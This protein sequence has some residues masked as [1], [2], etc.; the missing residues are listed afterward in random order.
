[1]TA[2]TPVP[3]ASSGMPAR[4]EQMVPA[5]R[6]DRPA[7]AARVE[8]AAAPK[9]VEQGRDPASIRFFDRDGRPVGPPPSFAITLLQA[10]REA[11]MPIRTEPQG[12]PGAGLAYGDA[13]GSQPPD[14]FDR[15][16]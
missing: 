10:Q 13:A 1:M 14:R 9:P 15:R 4:A 2:L 5:S 7:P 12:R 11:V 16:M 8:T 3:P 6:S